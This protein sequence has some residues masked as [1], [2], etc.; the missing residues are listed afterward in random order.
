M[1]KVFL[2]GI[3]FLLLSATANAQVRGGLKIGGNLNFPRWKPVPL[4]DLKS[5]MSFN[6]G[7]VVDFDISKNFG[8]E[9]NLLYNNHRAN[10]DYSEFDLYYGTIVAL[11]IVTTLQSISIP[12]LAKFKFPSRQ[13]TPFLGIG[14]EFGL[15]L[16]HKSKLKISADGLTDE[17]TVDL[18][19]DTTA[20]NFALT[21]CVGLDIDLGRVILSPELRFSLGLTDID[22]TAIGTMKSNQLILLFGVKF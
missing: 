11:D 20:I 4:G 9:V 16:S 5:G 7:G 1:K 18:G 3:V 8:I 22:E 6:V 15:I 17:I 12:V 10:W 13:V 14:P 2:L 19:D 21:L